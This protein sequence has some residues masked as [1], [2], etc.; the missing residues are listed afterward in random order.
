MAEVWFTQNYFPGGRVYTFVESPVGN[1]TVAFVTLAECASIA[2]GWTEYIF[3]KSLTI[4][5]AHTFLDENAF[6]AGQEHNETAPKYGFRIAL[7]ELGR[8]LGLD[9]L[10]IMDPIGTV[11]H[12]LDSPII[13]MIDL[14]ALHVLAWEPFFSSSIVLYTDQQIWMNAWNVLGIS[15]NNQ[16]ATGI[17]GAAAICPLRA[18][19]FSF[20]YS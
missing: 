6:N 14:F 20:C 12:A 2:V 8:V 16:I 7:H 11:S 19:K 13:S 15:P 17:D 3:D 4:I 18:V 1:A 5:E 9:G 10:D